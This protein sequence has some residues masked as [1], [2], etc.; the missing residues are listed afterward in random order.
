MERLLTP[1]SRVVAAAGLTIC[2]AIASPAAVA[3]VEVGARM[4]TLRTTLPAAMVTS[5]LVGST[6]AAAAS[7][8]VIS[9]TIESVKSFN[10]PETVS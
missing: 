10:A 2:G 5:T 1:A 4:T 8:A 7:T 6:L 9:S 3:A